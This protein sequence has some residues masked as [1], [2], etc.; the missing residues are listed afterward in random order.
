MKR[1]IL[2]ALTAF[3]VLPPAA[4]CTSSLLRLERTDT[5]GGVWREVPANT[6]PITE[7]GALLDTYESATGFY[8]MRIEPVDQWVPLSMPLEDVPSFAV[9]IAKGLLDDLRNMDGDNGWEGAIL[10]PV[11]FPMY[12]LEV[13]TITTPD[14]VEFKV[15]LPERKVPVGGLELPSGCSFPGVGAERGFILVSTE[16]DDFPVVDY[17]M[18][19]PTRTEC[20]RKLA[21]SSAVQIFRFDDGFM[22]AENAKGELVAYLGSPPVWYPDEILE[23]CDREFEGYGDQQG[24]NN[25]EPPA[26]TGKPYSSYQAFKDDYLNSRRFQEARRRR[27]EAARMLW[28]IYTGRLQQQIIYVT[29]GQPILAFPDKE[30]KEFTLAD[31][32]L[33]YVTIQKLG[34]TIAGRKAGTTTY[35]ALFGD[36]G[37][38]DGYLAVV[39]ERPLSPERPTVGWTSWTFYSAGTWI[40]Q[41]RYTQEPGGNCWSGCGATAWAMLYGWFDYTGAAT[42]LIGGPE[43]PAPLY[44]DANVRDCIWYVVPEIGTYCV[45]DGGATN[46]WNMYKGYKWATHR[47]HSYSY[48]YKWTSP[49]LGWAWSGPRNKAIDAIKTDQ[50]PAIIAVGCTPSHAVVAY[51]YK[52]REWRG[53]FGEVWATEGRFLCNMGYGGGSAE[54]KNAAGTSFGLRANFW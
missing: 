47:G 39:S 23:L 32:T 22:A 52:Y 33:A 26:F 44:N 18:E 34:V 25:P 49:C 53:A 13:I 20:L 29:I 40:E 21:K 27:R 14:Y 2:L 37:T 1:T 3:L 42:N 50:R 7:E 35:H 5:P 31:P 11:A 15:I 54:W 9:N 24:E 19:G 38:A 36:G 10:G 51:R 41:R 30:V 28:D 8:R 17:A 43:T 45:G 16:E 46:H 4:F 48:S 12:A 6:L